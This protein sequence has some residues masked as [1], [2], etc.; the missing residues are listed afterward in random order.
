[1][2]EEEDE[3]EE[4]DGCIAEAPALRPRFGCWQVDGDEGGRVCCRA[5]CGRIMWPGVAG[6]AVAMSG[7]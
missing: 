6:V 5:P 7:L 3:T 2:S 4:R 1:M